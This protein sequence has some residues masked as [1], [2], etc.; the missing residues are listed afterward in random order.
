MDASPERAERM[1][2]WLAQVGMMVRHFESVPSSADLR[3]GG[4]IVIHMGFTK[5]DEIVRLC[6]SDRALFGRSGVA[7]SGGWSIFFGDSRHS[8]GRCEVLGFPLR[9]AQLYHALAESERLSGKRMPVAAEESHPAPPG[10]SSEREDPQGPV[11]LVEDNATNRR[12]A[13][14]MLEKL[15]LKVDTVENGQA[16][17]ERCLERSYKIVL[18]DIQMPVMDGFEAT[19][20]IRNHPKIDLQPTIIALTAGALKVHHD[21]AREVGMDDFLTK[22]FVM[23]QLESVIRRGLG[24]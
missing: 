16:A 15:G 12:V 8:V 18:M 11:L 23:D 14:I 4:G 7:E 5:G 10:E 9:Y 22:P 24:K 2:G 13:Q 1:C 20:I 21:N 3:D 17:V 6:E 19:R